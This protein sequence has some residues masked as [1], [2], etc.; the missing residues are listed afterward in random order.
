[1]GIEIVRNTK[2]PTEEMEKELKAQMKKIEEIN[3]AFV[4]RELKMI[5]LKKEIEELRKRLKDK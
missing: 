1:M 3:K 5:E 2:V 4:D